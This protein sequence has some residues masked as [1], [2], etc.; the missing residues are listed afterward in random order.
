M[1][2]TNFIGVGTYTIIREIVV[3]KH[4]K[5]VQIIIDSYASPTKTILINSFVLYFTVNGNEQKVKTR[6]LNTP[7]NPPEIG[8]EYIVAPGATGEWEGWDGKIAY[9]DTVKWWER[10]GEFQVLVEDEN[11]I[12]IPDGSGGWTRDPYK[13]NDEEFEYFF[14]LEKQNQNGNNVLKL[15][16]EFLLTRPEFANAESI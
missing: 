5:T 2:I 14:G 4:G 6:Q 12:V 13:L 15:G 7:P 1:A 3:N 8:V 11:V 9:H 16:Y 10:T